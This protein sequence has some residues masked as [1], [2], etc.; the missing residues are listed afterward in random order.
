MV[1]PVDTEAAL[2]HAR[3]LGATGVISKNLPM[4]RRLVAAQE[5]AA[6]PAI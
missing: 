2:D 4:L 5:P 3:R 6:V 1:W